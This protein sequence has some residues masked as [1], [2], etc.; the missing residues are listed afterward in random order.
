MSDVN[1]GSSTAAESSDRTRYEAPQPAAA[2]LPGHL[3]SSTAAMQGEGTR[4]GVALGLEE[5]TAV[6][7][8]LSGQASSTVAR[9]GEGARGGV[10]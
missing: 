10:P 1:P 2:K 3:A 9:R 8:P 6:D 5:A 4:G 7:N